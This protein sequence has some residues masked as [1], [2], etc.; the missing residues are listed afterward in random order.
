M[1]MLDDE[2]ETK[3]FA[4]PENRTIQT[5]NREEVM[6]LFEWLDF[7]DLQGHSLTKCQDFI[8]LV[9]RATSVRCEQVV[10]GSPHV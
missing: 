10:C 8:D 6:R 2:G 7:D 3:G 9:E 1:Q 4:P 5:M